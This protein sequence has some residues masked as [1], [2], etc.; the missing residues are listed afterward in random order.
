M[1]ILLALVFLPLASCQNAL[2]NAKFTGGLTYDPA[3][4]TF[5]LQIGK[6]PISKAP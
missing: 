4:N 3:T 5:G 6:E 2:N 1:K